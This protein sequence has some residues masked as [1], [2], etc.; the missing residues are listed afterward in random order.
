[1]I[2]LLIF[3]GALFIGA[4]ILY[5]GWRAYTSID[6]S[7]KF[8]KETKALNTQIQE[9][10]AGCGRKDVLL[11]RGTQALETALAK[12]QELS[13]TLITTQHALE[14][15]QAQYATLLGQKKSSEVRTGGIV[16][17]IAPFLKDYPVDSGTARFIGDPVDFCHFLDDKIVFVEVKSGES[18]LSSKQRKI[19]D[20]ISA[21]KVEFILYRVRGEK[22]TP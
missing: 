13:T 7:D 9:L 18:Q 8:E 4:G 12:H 21:G 16:E 2:E 14:F 1:M 22:E 5:L 17:Q 11:S 10:I 15:Q 3:I 20:L 6:L 19:R